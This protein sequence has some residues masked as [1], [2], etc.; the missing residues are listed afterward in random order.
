M[1]K[2]I[3]LPHF[4]IASTAFVMPMN[5]GMQGAGGNVIKTVMKKQ[6]LS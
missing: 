3:L 5:R 6:Q 1:W 2:Q 4:C